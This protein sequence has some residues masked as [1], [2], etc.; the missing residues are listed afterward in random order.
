MA[1][2]PGE[3]HPVVAGCCRE[4]SRKGAS[5]EALSSSGTTAFL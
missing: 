5:A 2:Y 1:S 4:Y 3:R